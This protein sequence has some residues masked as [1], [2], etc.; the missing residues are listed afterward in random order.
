MGNEPYSSYGYVSGGD[1]F[2]VT[3]DEVRRELRITEAE[4][5]AAYDV[6][7]EPSVNEAKTRKS[8]SAVQS[9][10]RAARQSRRSANGCRRAR[11]S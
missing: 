10:D 4:V 6:L 11:Y 9:V 5:L 2:T 3:V 1:T 8:P 7:L